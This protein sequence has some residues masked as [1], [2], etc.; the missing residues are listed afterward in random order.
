[1]LNLRKHIHFVCYG[2]FMTLYIFTDQFIGTKYKKVVCVYRW[3]T[4]VLISRH[5]KNT[6]DWINLHNIHLISNHD[7]LFLENFVSKSFWFV[8]IK[9]NPRFPSTNFT[10]LLREFFWW[11]TWVG[12]N[13]L[14]LRSSKTSIHR[15][16]LGLLIGWVQKKTFPD[17]LK[18]YI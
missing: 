13:Y 12:V 3:C 8:K 1:M 10:Q 7:L 2:L 5:K 6:R 4:N 17:G 14:D 15:G 16:T 11:S 18:Y 9:V